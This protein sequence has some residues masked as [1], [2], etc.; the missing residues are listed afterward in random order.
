MSSCCSKHKIITFEAQWASI[1]DFFYLVGRERGTKYWSFRGW[2]GENE[3]CL[4]CRITK[5]I[6][7]SYARRENR[8]IMAIGGLAKGGVVFVLINDRRFRCGITELWCA[9]VLVKAPIHLNYFKP[10]PDR[11]FRV[12]KLSTDLR[13]REQRVNADSNHRWFRFCSFIFQ[14]SLPVLRFVWLWKRNCNNKFG[15]W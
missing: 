9:I 10:S 2:E 5:I 8:D 12:E 7:V 11:W 1:I 6:F 14:L 4:I 15:I 13:N 3:R